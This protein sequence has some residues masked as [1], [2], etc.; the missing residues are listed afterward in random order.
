MT[1]EIFTKY[2][3]GH[4]MKKTITSFFFFCLAA[5]LTA[6]AQASGKVDDSIYAGLLEKYV[7]NGM[8]DY[9]G[10]KKEEATL[11]QYLRILE[12]TDTQILSPK[13]R[14]AFFINAYNAWTIKLILNAYP[15]IKSIKELGGIF[16]TPWDKKI[17]RIDRKIL[18]LDNIEHDILRPEY[19]DPRIH[20]VVNCASKSCPPLRSEPYRGDI[21]DQQLTDATEIFINNPKYNRLDGN[22]LYVSS[23]F[24]WY[25]RDFNDDIPGFINKYARR[26]S[27]EELKRNAGKIEIKYLDYDW[28]LNG[29]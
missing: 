5:G 16:K 9:Q 21:L 6:T 11:D 19:K 12:K 10:L 14:F 17:V 4:L 25:S 29:K 28:S 8:V 13:E 20:F 26:E 24:K 2:R 23:L 15:D 1:K 27:K 3:K 22:T 18:T 7:K